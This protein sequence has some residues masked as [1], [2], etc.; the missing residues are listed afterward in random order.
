MYAYR[1]DHSEKNQL[2]WYGTQCRDTE[3]EADRE[4]DDGDNIREWTGLK[5]G[6]A[7]REAEDREG[8]RKLAVR[9]SVVP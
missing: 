5:L 2:K 6:E 9:S 7:L 1:P 4:I 8:C 3:R